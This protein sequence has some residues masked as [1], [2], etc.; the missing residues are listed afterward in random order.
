ANEER[1]AAPKAPG[2]IR[3]G[4]A[5]PADKSSEHVLSGEALAKELVDGL[6]TAPY[7]AIPLRSASPAEEDAEARQRQCDFVLYA[8][9]SS[10]KTSTPG[11]MGNMMRKA[12]GGGSP[13]ELHEAKVDYKVFPAGS[14]APR[15]NKSAS[16]KTGSFTLK[17]AMGLARFAGKLYFG[18]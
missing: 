3:I 13:T 9:L 8:E 1:W 11:K 5:T 12:S 7:E 15:M 10:L 16:A 17:R 4:V 18:A 6:T 2:T 14:V